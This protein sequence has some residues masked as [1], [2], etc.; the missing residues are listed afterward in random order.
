M[1]KMYIEN[2]ERCLN[3]KKFVKCSEEFK[4]RIVDCEKFEELKRSIYYVV[5]S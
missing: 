1:R 3:C 2:L 4:E 5:K